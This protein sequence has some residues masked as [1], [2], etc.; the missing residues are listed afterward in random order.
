MIRD[1][2]LPTEGIH[3]FRDY[4]GYTVSG[5]GRIRRGLLFRSG[6]HVAATD[7]DL[8][9]ISSLDIRTV[10]DLRGA[11]ERTNNPCRRGPAF[12]AHVIAYEGET[13]S[14]PPHM[15]VDP[16]TSTAE[17]ARRRMVAVYTR[18]PR[19]PAMIEMFGRYLRA[20]DQRDG[21]SLVH[22]FAGKDRT[23]VAAMLLL[24]VLGASRDDQMEEFLL[25]NHAPTLG[26]L[27]AQS[28]PGIEARLGRQLD[29]ES[30]RALLEVHEDY[31]STYV[32]EIEKDHGSVD[33]F[34]ENALGVD[35]PMKERLR[36]RFVA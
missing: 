5:G 28:V 16:E 11:S 32:A 35:E 27:R 7:E 6:Q 33:S 15:D 26:V 17:F 19:N 22:C 21:A 3:N 20:L 29:E 36:D 2:F 1:K 4:G 10:I 34:V 31:L 30:I 8:A 23:G 13:T 25:T 18:M 24:H 14:S 9:A 12:E